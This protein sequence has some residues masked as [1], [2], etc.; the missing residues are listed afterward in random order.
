VRVP[1]SRNRCGQSTTVSGVRPLA[2]AAAAT[3]TL[4]VEPGGYRWLIAR[5]SSGLSSS[6]ASFLYSRWIDAGSCDEI[7]FGSYVG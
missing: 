7:R 5:L 4:N 3:I 2:S 6:L 1:G